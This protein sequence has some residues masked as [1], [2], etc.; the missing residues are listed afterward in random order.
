MAEVKS[1]VDLSLE[2]KSASLTWDEATMTWDE[3]TSTWN[4]PMMSLTKESKTKISL[5]FA[6]TK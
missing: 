1:M 6:E 5:T 2:D 4:A 3:N